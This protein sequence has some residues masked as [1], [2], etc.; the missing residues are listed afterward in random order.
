MDGLELLCL[1]GTNVLL[2][3]MP[4]SAS[5]WNDRLYHTIDEIA[6]RGICPVFAHVAALQEQ[7]A[8]ASLRGLL[9]FT[10]G[11]GI[12]PQKRPPYDAAFILL[13]EPPASV[14]MPPWAIRLVLGDST[15]EDA[16]M[17]EGIPMER[18]AEDLAELPEL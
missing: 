16:A 6:E 15:L 18:D 13:K 12:Y 14:E 8:F 4:F 3:E 17:A 2:L 7:G 9:Y 11:M 10:D 5:V 1:E